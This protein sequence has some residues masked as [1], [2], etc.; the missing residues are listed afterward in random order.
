MAV[1]LEAAWSEVRARLSLGEWLLAFD[2]DGTLAPLAPKPELAR[3][4]DVVRERLA[5]LAALPGLHLMIN[6]G[7]A[8]LDLEQ[9]AALPNLILAGNHGLEARG[10]GWSFIEPAALPLQSKVHQ[11]AEDLRREVG[12]IP[13]IVIEDKGLSLSVHYRLVESPLVGPLRERVESEVRK[14]PEF[15]CRQGHLVL[16]IRPQLG[17][18][19]GTILGRV[20]RWLELPARQLVYCGDDRTDEDAFAAWPAAITIKVGEPG[21]AT[22]ARLQVERPADVAELLRQMIQIR[23]EA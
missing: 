3:M 17:A 20:L 4:P 13:G 12:Y 2:F 18:D 19:K 7:R 11:L 23:R 10:P 16:E 15:R 6:S 1:P 8:L 9:R 21:C 14:F 5:E 22:Q